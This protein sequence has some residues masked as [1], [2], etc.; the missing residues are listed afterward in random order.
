MRELLTNVARHAGGASAELVV[1]RAG[2]GAVV[3]VR[4]GGP[5]FVVEDVP[6]HRRGLR[7]SVV[8]RVAA[9]GG[10]AEV[11]SAPGTGRRPA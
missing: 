3:V 2:A 7:A 9:V 4:D 5:G 6:E 1:S 8:E 11:E 10:A